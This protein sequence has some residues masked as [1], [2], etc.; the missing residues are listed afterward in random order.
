MEPLWISLLVALIAALIASLIST[1]AARVRFSAKPG[2]RWAL[3]ILFL[4]PLAVPG[5]VTWCL[6]ILVYGIF[7]HTPKPHATP[8]MMI[9]AEV[10]WA[11]P[12][13]YLCAIMGFRKVSPESVDAARLQGMGRCGIF[14]RIWFPPALPWIATGLAAGLLRCTILLALAYA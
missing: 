13:F 6:T 10:L 7:W 4:L 3:D 12:V 5:I 9:P 1:L 14:W 2:L 8:A 11:L